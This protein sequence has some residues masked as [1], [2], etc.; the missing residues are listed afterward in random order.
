M[1]GRNSAARGALLAVL[2]AAGRVQSQKQ[3]QRL[4][5]WL[6][7][8]PALPDAYPL[9][10]SWRVP[11]EEAPQPLLRHEVLELLAAEPRLNGLR[12]WVSTLPVTGRVPVAN[13]DAPWLVVRP[14][15]DPV[16]MPGH[17]VVLP[18]RPR[19][20]TVVTENGDTCAV[21]H[22]AGREAMAYVEACEPARAR[23]VDWA[24]I[25]QPDGRV[26]RFGVAPWNQEAQDIPA[27]GA[28]IWAPS[29]ELRVPEKLSDRLMRFLATQ[30]PAPDPAVQVLQLPP[31]AA[32]AFSVRSRNAAVTANDW[33]EVGLLQTPSARMAEPGTLS[34][35]FSHV[36]PYTRGNVFLQPLDWLEAGFRYSEVANRPYGP[37]GG[38][39]AKDKSFDA[40]FRL[41]RESVHVPEF[42][43]GF[44]DLAGTGLFSSEYFVAS[45]RYGSL[46]LSLGLAWGYMAGALRQV[47]FGQGGN[48]DFHNYFRGRA[49]LF[50]GL[51]Y[52]TPWLPLLV[53]LERESNNYIQEPFFNAQPQRTPWNFALTYRATRGLDLSLGVERGNRLMLGLAFY[54][55]LD[56][57]YAPKVD[58]SPRVAYA[59]RPPQGPSWRA[60]AA[61]IARQTGCR[62][63]QV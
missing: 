2:V 57:I 15:R 52:Q 31:S 55:R 1:I 19:S 25:A 12:Q 60:T 29:R 6:L 13:A 18:R 44:R 47:E 42:A 58:D 38:Q 34:V 11:S 46:D 8:Q 53:K 63:R 62:V 24:W 50:G 41:W 59:L 51:Q 33:G 35:T 10:L 28:W 21:T 3:P 48:F 27:P 39:T 40:K 45:K 9:G 17:T 54:G 23:S 7:E 14:N 56:E 4:S 43:V 16:L 30:G 20:V 22:A 5:N 37:T 49:A 61:E 32:S 26:E 36:W